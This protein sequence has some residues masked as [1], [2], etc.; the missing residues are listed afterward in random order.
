MASSRTAFAE[1]RQN[2]EL[3][4]SLVARD[5]KSRYKATALGHLWSLANP[6]TIMVVYTVVFS[7]IMRV[8]PPPGENSGLDVFALWLL[9]ALLPW[10]YFTATVNSGTTSLVG[11]AHL[12]KKV[13]ISRLSLVV[14]NSM[15]GV[16]TWLIEMSVL[17]IAL[18]IAGSEPWLYLVPVLVV[19]A[20]LYLFATGISLMLSILNVYIRDTQHFTTILLQVWFFLTPVLYPI[21]MVEERSNAAGAFFGVFSI[22]GLYMANPMAQ[23]V[24]AFRSLL[25]DNAIPPVWN[26]TLCAMWGIG[27]F[28]AGLWIFKRY[29]KRLAEEL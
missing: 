22:Y 1:L 13:P 16:V 10:L 12:I 26:L 9:C 6:L 27:T 8:Q 3:I 11:N 5:L 24:L 4:Q 28:L 7:F 14:S 23:F 19:M 15:T 2:R 17:L 29:E 21:V 20:A 18:V 25:Y